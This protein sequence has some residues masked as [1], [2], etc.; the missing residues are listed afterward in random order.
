M[1]NSVEKL[2]LEIRADMRD[3]KT[4]KEELKTIKNEASDT[5]KS[6]GDSLKSAI[7]GLVAGVSAL[8]IKSVMDSAVSE[9]NKLEKTMLGLQAT[10]KLTG[11]NFEGLKSK[12]NDLAKDGVLSIDQ[13]STAMKT[14][15]AQGIQV[16]KAFSLLDAAKKVGA[17]NNIVG[18]TGQAV[19]DFV[20][21][22]QTGSAELAENLDP[23]IVKVV[24]SL[25]GYEKVASDATAKQKL[26]NAVIEK[27]SKL[28]GDYEKFLSSGAQAQV[29]FNSASTALSQ[30]LGQKL[31]P[32]YN[33][34]Y[35]AGT[36]VLEG[37]TKL[38][39]ALDSTTVSVVAF[40]AAGFAAIAGFA[41]TAAL[42]PGIFGGIGASITAA[43]G[44]I[45]AVIAAIGGAIIIVNKLRREWGDSKDRELLNERNALIQQI[46]ALQNAG[47]KTKELAAA[48]ERLSQI[49]NTL[50]AS[51]A[52][53]LKALDAE[54]LSIE[55]KIALIDALEKAKKR[56][57]VESDLKDRSLEELKAKSKELD[58]EIAKGSRLVAAGKISKE[59]FEEELS[60]VAA[61]K[62]IV[63]A[64]IESRVGTSTSTTKTP[65]TVPATKF[66][67]ARYI[68][69]RDELK[70][71]DDDFKKTLAV[72]EA[73]RKSELKKTK[74]PARKAEIEQQAQ[75]EVESATK[76]R[77]E[78]QDDAISQ[79]RQ[80]QA[81]YLEQRV[82]AELEAEKQ[83]FNAQIANVYRLAEAKQISDKEA[84]EQIQKLREQHARNNAKIYA[85]SFARTMQS[86]D[87]IA[88]GFAGIVNAKD[89]G[90]ALSGFG[91]MA[92][93]LSG[94]SPALSALGP[95]GAGIGAAGSI[96]STLTSLFGKSEE[97]RQREAEEQRRRDEEARKLLELQANYQKA[98]LALQEAQA[99]LPFENLQRNL[100]L[101]D[102]QAQQE[103]L[104]GG[105]KTAIEARRL[106]R[107]QELMQAV[108]SEQAGTI[109]GDALFKDVQATPESLTRFLSERAAQQ[110]SVN[111][112][113]T[114]IDQLV[115]YRGSAA[116]LRDLT[117]VLYGQASGLSGSV[118]AELL[119]EVLNKVTLARDAMNNFAAQG[120][121]LN[122]VQ[123]TTIDYGLFGKRTDD[124]IS[125]ITRDTA[126]AESLLSV[127]QES[128]ANQIAIEENTRKT[129]E[130]TAKLTQ[131]DERR[132]SFLDL[133]N[134]RI[135]SQGLNVDFQR[136]KLPDS[137]ATTILAT[138][139]APVV[140]S[141]TVSELKKVVS[142]I[143]EMNEW[144]A[145]IAANTDNRA[146]TNTGDFDN[147]LIRKLAEIRA[148]RIS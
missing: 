88:R 99:K 48:K 124:L 43:L 58:A 86:A 11:N 32:A 97:Q 135:F 84:E 4:L 111:L 51:Y 31:Q 119:N 66:I 69:L 108:L 45:G 127:I 56:L 138:S 147:Y 123:I 129:A 50:V 140:V 104:A 81:E 110:P 62:A 144:L 39:G 146:N 112:I 23:S 41:K 68:E 2:L 126:T 63:E 8:K 30:T 47:D 103:I 59:R 107:R 109:A 117:D 90:G 25:G 133:G 18:D 131:L 46:G 128:L 102:I 142:G 100:R 40:G 95:I 78:I 36:A 9:F 61:E 89:A 141:D 60:K 80:Q 44:P 121:D 92:Q 79:I 65:V 136:V 7:G 139:P 15:L 3:L 38:I 83:R 148:R 64:E 77:Q 118:P 6:V 28:T 93:G 26:I 19:A 1:A 116:G 76:K 13:A 91:G 143:E 35:K 75:F 42:L 101:A 122:K 20:K 21:F 105:D 55:K 67:E 134:R 115:A 54:N 130:N 37:L 114:I 96:V 137:V 57:T 120:Y 73:R 71:A 33:A 27:G 106:A 16:D 24:K 72:I 34:L 132:T 145:I 12:V 52:P 17:F 94:L 125:E 5:G 49:N 87:A 53:L 29:T 85:D 10:A 82:Q 14:L 74:D 98:M 22:L 113:K 70:K